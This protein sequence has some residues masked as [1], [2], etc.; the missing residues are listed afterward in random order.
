MKSRKVQVKICPTKVGE[1][2]FWCRPIWYH[3]EAPYS[4]NQYLD[5][6]FFA[7]SYSK[8][9][10]AQSLNLKEA[11]MLLSLF[12]NASFSVHRF[13]VYRLEERRKFFL[14]RVEFLRF[15]RGGFVLAFS[16]PTF[17]FSKL[18]TAACSND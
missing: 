9:A 3:S 15:Y 12:S 8:V 11:L 16:L 14:K 17:F 10:L 2:H 6:D 4:P 13:L 1:D 7:T 5:R 18:P